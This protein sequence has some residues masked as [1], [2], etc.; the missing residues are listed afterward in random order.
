M[1]KAPNLLQLLIN[2]I[3]KSAKAPVG[4]LE[5]T[6]EHEQLDLFEFTQDL[7]LL[8][9]QSSFGNSKGILIPSDR[10]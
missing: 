2:R 5:E 10:G 3:Y 9:P 4:L 1:K 7:G 6:S 8:N